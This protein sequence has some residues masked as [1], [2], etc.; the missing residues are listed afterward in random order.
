MNAVVVTTM[1]SMI[2][3]IS[4]PAAFLVGA[5]PILYEESDGSSGA[6]IGQVETETIVEVAVGATTAA[7][8]NNDCTD[9]PDFHYKEKQQRDCDWVKQQPGKRC[10]LK[11]SGEP[12]E[13]SCRETCNFQYCKTIE[14]SKTKLMV[15]AYYYP[16]WGDDFHRGNPDNPDS[17]LRR[18]LIEP[19]Q[20]PSLGEYDDT[21]RNVIKRHLA[22]SRKNNIGLWVTSW[23][24][25]DKRE[26]MNIKNNILVSPKL[27]NHKIAIFY[28]TTGRI[29]EKYNYSLDNVRTDLEY[30]CQEYFNHPNYYTMGVDADG[31]ADASSQTRRPAFFVYLTRKLEDL[32]ILP[33]AIALMREGARDGGC[34]EIFIV[35]DQV[36]QGP[37]KSENELIPFDLL[38]A[39][40]NYDV[41]GSMRGER[42]GGYIGTREKVTEYYQEQNLWRAL[43][44]DRNCAFIPAVSPGFNDRGVR[45]EIERIPLSRRLNEN[46]PEGSLF[47][48]AL[49]EARTIVDPKIGNMIMV[50]SMNE[51][52]EDTQIEPCFAVGKSNDS[53]NLP[54]NLTYGLEYEGYGSLYLKIL[55]E[56]TQSWDPSMVVPAPASGA[57]TDGA[58][59]P[60]NE[61]LDGNQE[62]IVTIS[63]TIGWELE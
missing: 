24:G 33:D 19:Q 54:R 41:Y 39:V 14:D 50:N 40:T 47:R 53:T 42:N 3:I 32:E 61:I 29:R 63:D 48:A 52:H 58:R 13:E 30:L 12:V 51:W 25:R 18:Q 34:G 20:F 37:P 28:E 60:A 59:I 7:G 4:L 22:W 2:A 45:P 62:D 10:K 16:W 9:D 15:G 23:W 49:E 6:T 55:K 27:Q 11:Q 5:S 57:K 17:Y 1:I 46:A 21:K 38:D 8:A 43:A 26:D 35:G 36:F 56:E 31:N 44:K